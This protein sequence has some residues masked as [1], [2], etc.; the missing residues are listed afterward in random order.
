MQLSDMPFMGAGAREQLGYGEE[1]ARCQRR[2]AMHAGVWQLSV[3][4]LS[5]RQLPWPLPHDLA[6]KHAVLIV[7]AGFALQQLSGQ[8]WRVFVTGVS[9]QVRTQTSLLMTASKKLPISPESR[10][11][12]K[13]NTLVMHALPCE[14]GERLL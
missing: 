12:S 7:V 14:L 6:V 8:L 11:A 1:A 9:G 2:R 3:E 13:I 4:K 10:G 5:H